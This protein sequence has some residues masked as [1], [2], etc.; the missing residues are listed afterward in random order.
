MRN[1][2][3]KLKQKNLVQLDTRKNV[4][5]FS[6]RTDRQWSSMPREAVLPPSL[7]VFKT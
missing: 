3:N 2:R 7:E 6:T 4:T 5:F 1:S